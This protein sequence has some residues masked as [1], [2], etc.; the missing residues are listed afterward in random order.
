MTVNLNYL[1]PHHT[2]LDISNIK[3]KYINVCGLTDNKL[4]VLCSLLGDNTLMFVAET[5]YIN[6]GERLS[7]PLVLASTWTSRRHVARRQDHGLL[8]LCSILLAP[9][10]SVKLVTEFS[11]KINLDNSN[12]SIA[13]VY[14]P[15]SL[16]PYAIELELGT[17]GAV[18][19]LLGDFNV[20]LGASVGDS[21]S[22]PPERLASIS[23]HLDRADMMH[24]RPLTST[25]MEI[26]RPISRVDHVFISSSFLTLFSLVVMNAPVKTDH[27][28]L[29]VTLT[30]PSPILTTA[31]SLLISG[32]S[33]PTKR[34]CVSALSNRVMARL[35]C[36][37]V[38]ILCYSVE[39]HLTHLLTLTSDNPMSAFGIVEFLDNTLVDI[40]QIALEETVGYYDPSITRT[41]KTTSS[42]LSSSF[43]SIYTMDYMETVR[44]F[45]KA[46]RMGLQSRRLESDTEAMSLMEEAFHHY[47]NLFQSSPEQS[48]EYNNLAM[49]SLQSPPSFS[50]LLNPFESTASVSWAIKNYPAGKSPGIDGI[51]GRVL[52]CLLEAPSFLVCLSKL[53]ALCF[54]HGHTP[55][56]WNLSIIHPIPK[57]TTTLSNLITDHRPISLTV[58]FR[59]LFEKILLPDLVQTVTL[60]CGQAGFRTGFSCMTH[61]LTANEA[62]YRGARINV[63]VDLKTAYDRVSI[64]RLLEKLTL[65]NLHPQLI[66][67]LSSLFL[68][69]SSKVAVNGALSPS[70]LRERGLFQGSLLSPWLFNIYID[71]LAVEL[72]ETSTNKLISSESLEPTIPP[73][74]L[75]ADD[76]LLQTAS[77]ETMIPM[78]AKL[79]NWCSKNGMQINVAKSG[80]LGFP[81]LDQTLIPFCLGG[82]PIPVISTTSSHHHYVYLGLP[83]ARGGVDIPAHV[84][85]RCAQ[86]NRLL[87]GLTS[88]IAT[89]SWPEAAKIAIYKAFI[90]PI[91]EYAAPLVQGAYFSAEPTRPRKGKGKRPK[92]QQPPTTNSLIAS[93][94]RIQ[95]KALYWIF[96]RRTP[97]PVLLSLSGLPPMTLRLEELTSRFFLHLSR[98]NTSNPL[99]EI[100][101]QVDAPKSHSPMLRTILTLNPNQSQISNPN[102]NQISNPSLAQFYYEKRINTYTSTISLLSKYILPGCRVRSGMDRSLLVTSPSLRKSIIRWRCNATKTPAI[103]PSCGSCFLRVHLARCP[104]ALKAFIAALGPSLATSFSDASRCIQGKHHYTPLDHLLNTKQ[105]DLF[106]KYHTSLLA[107][108]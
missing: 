26:D 106:E 86:A 55:Q 99:N 25:T 82:E 37:I 81:N 89:I 27:P 32:L 11:I 47:S 1:L 22:G 5:W 15:P 57:N 105:Y 95:K 46:Q 44:L 20:R 50:S 77:V 67:I 2:S 38:Q 3:I 87:A 104:H 66:S 84:E 96:G 68:T 103:C 39:E 60:N 17:I 59:R 65:K 34:P 29:Q 16:S 101:S 63:F 28:M 80:V 100:I 36:N 83:F 21:I 42:S 107:S 30:F 9:R 12:P 98:M 33:G 54:E 78:L 108:F 69:C 75:F 48:K 35:F 72:N 91:I 85:R 24:L 23:A 4:S 70:F 40:V 102:P 62:Y 79:E 43:P 6:H 97:G 94:E 14:L 10:V 52:K 41:Q 31:S 19:L 64:P 8:L 61:I 45:K 93:M 58:M 90:R 76:I 88:N 7:N 53:F 92:Y 73:C 13:A 71:D 74:L 18:S 51:D 56:R 49:S